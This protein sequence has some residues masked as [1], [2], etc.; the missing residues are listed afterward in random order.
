MSNESAR[1][2]EQGR[3]ATEDTHTE[4]QQSA[5]IPEI[6]GSGSDPAGVAERTLD[7]DIN[8]L[9]ELAARGKE[10]ENGITLAQ[11]ALD[12]RSRSDE[13]RV[14][15]MREMMEAV[16]DA[17]TRDP[18]EKERRETAKFRRGLTSMLGLSGIVS[19]VFLYRVATTSGSLPGM[20]LFTGLSLFCLAVTALFA[21]GATITVRTIQGLIKTA[22]VAPQAQD[23]DRQKQR[24]KR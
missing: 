20:F 23:R 11:Q 19:L 22:F 6:L 1:K 2:E 16:I 17:K 3:Q 21:S 18:D 14:R 4:P 13:Q 5:L 8:R 15:H 9:L 12:L 7:V 24:R 10:A